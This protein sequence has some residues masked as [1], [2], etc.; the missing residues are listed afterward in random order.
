[1]QNP[2]LFILLSTAI[3]VSGCD[4]NRVQSE[5]TDSMDRDNADTFDGDSS[6]EVSTTE[7]SATDRDTDTVS[8]E[9]ITTCENWDLVIEAVGCP[10]RCHCSPPCEAYAEAWVLCVLK[11]PQGQCICDI[12]GE[13]NCEGSFKDDE[14]TALCYDEYA[15]WWECGK[16]SD[17][18]TTSYSR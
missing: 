2:T 3:I 16:Q 1:M 5:D 9:C 8:P 17:T 6:L 13:L 15:A 7:D 10:D 12:Y 11:D 4:N 14:G 18:E